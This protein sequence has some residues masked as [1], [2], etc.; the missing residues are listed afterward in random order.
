MK[1]WP[2]LIL[3]ACAHPQPK[4]SPVTDADACERE[5]STV[6]VRSDNCTEMQLRIDTLLQTNAACKALY[7][8]RTFDV[9]AK[10]KK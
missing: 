9:C 10:V 5:I 8:G 1:P 6:I 7:E 3:A 2:L 4:T